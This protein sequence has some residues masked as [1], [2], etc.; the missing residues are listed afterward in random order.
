MIITARIQLGTDAVSLLE[1]LRSQVT[2]PEQ[3]YGTLKDKCRYVSIQ[4]D[5]STGE[6]NSGAYIGND[7][8]VGFAGE[9]AG[10]VVD[11]SSPVF[12]LEDFAGGNIPL[13]FWLKQ[14]ADA[15]APRVL[16]TII[17]DRD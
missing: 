3:R 14:R 17:Q 1:Y 4:M 8:R 16:V 10:R 9:F 6:P 11:A 7:N 12:E 13:N 2:S 5:A 15:E